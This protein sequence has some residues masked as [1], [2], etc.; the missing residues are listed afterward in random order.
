MKNVIQ[1]PLQHALDRSQRYWTSDGIPEIVMG[2]FWLMWGSL[3]LLPTLFPQRAPARLMQVIL[4]VAISA[5]GLLMKRLIHGWKERVT[6][7]RTGYIELRQPSKRLR[8][9]IPLLL[10]FVIAVVFAVLVRFGDRSLREWIP[11]GLGLLLAI[12]MLQASWKMRTVRLALFSGVVAAVGIALTVLRVEEE[13]STALMLLTAGLACVADG[14]LV[15][16][17]YKRTHPM[18]LVDAQ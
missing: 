12:G 18:P 10:S 8:Y 17:S 3:V 13:R 1:D 2:G 11:L 9:G 16:R 4:V 14:L 7:P 5:A 15:L 6:F